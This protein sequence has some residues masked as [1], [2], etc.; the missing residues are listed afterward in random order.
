MMSLSEAFSS[1]VIKNFVIN[2]YR[3]KHRNKVILT[4][5]D[6]C[7]LAASCFMTGWSS[8]Y[9]YG[10]PKWKQISTF[11]PFSL[12]PPSRTNCFTH[13]FPS[14]SNFIINFLCT[15]LISY[16][17][18]FQKTFICSKL[19]CTFIMICNLILTLSCFSHFLQGANETIELQGNSIITYKFH[20]GTFGNKVERE[21]S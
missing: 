17:I 2:R 14:I 19:L 18:L 11:C 7:C 3:K 15:P 16:Y 9:C 13:N 4:N 21:K 10:S 5:N 20:L 1:T 12:T 6:N 8:K